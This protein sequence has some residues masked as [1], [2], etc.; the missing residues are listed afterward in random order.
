MGP[1]RAAERFI[2]EGVALYGVGAG[3]WARTDSVVAAVG[4][5]FVAA[6]A[7]GVLGVP[8]TRVCHRS[9]YPVRSGS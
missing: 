9:P 3:A 1:V 6:S 5:Q 4:I 7:G 2:C 8:A